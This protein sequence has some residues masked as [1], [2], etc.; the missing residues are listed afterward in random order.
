MYSNRRLNSSSGH[1]RAKRR[2]AGFT[3][4]ELLVVIAIIAV[5]IGLLLPA[6]QKVREAANVASVQDHL[7]QIFD[8]EI[9]FFGK[10]QTFTSNFEDLRKAGLP[11]GI[12]W[13][14]NSGYLYKLSVGSTAGAAVGKQNFDQFKIQADPAEVGKTGIQS[15][16]VTVIWDGRTPPTVP[17][18]PCSEIPG[19]AEF[20]NMMFLQI[21]A[22]GA[23]EVADDIG[24]FTHKSAFGDGSVVPTPDSI[25]TYLRDPATVPTIFQ[26]LD[27]NGDGHV[28]LSDIFSPRNAGF[29]KLLPAVQRAMALGAGHE[30]FGGLEIHL[31]D[32]GPAGANGAPVLCPSDPSQPCPI[33]PEPPLNSR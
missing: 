22:L 18:G 19:A 23:E 8:A 26:G 17:P 20:R 10:N 12:N 16:Q 2:Q 7:R 11:G 4:I 3:L 32:L 15:C 6:V 13:G 25:R 30:D 5:L 33:F 9:A 27:V 21:A 24:E 1:N 14:D 28:T 31:S 29:G